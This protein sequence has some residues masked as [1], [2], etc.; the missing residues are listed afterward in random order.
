MLDSG[1]EDVVVAVESDVTV[2]GCTHMGVGL[3]WW[4]VE[5]PHARL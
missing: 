2:V 4:M 1:A 3:L 5:L